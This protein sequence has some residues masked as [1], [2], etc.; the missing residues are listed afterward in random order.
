MNVSRNLKPHVALVSLLSA[1][2]TAASGCS[3]VVPRDGVPEDELDRIAQNL[4]YTLVQLPDSNP[5]TTTVQLSEPVTPFGR[6]VVERVREAGYGIQSVPDDRGANYLRYRVETI[7]SELGTETRYAVSIGDVSVERAYESRDGRL[8]PVSPQRVAGSDPDAVELNDDLFGDEPDPAIAAIAFEDEIAPS[9]VD[10]TGGRTDALAVTDDR[11]PA[12]AT[13]PFGARVKRNLYDGLSSNYA[14]LFAAYGDVS[15]DTIVF[16]NDSMRLGEA[17]KR[18]IE[19]YAERL[20]PDTDLL[21]VIGCSHGNTAIPAGNAL[22]A[23]GRANRVKEALIF[24]GVPAA[25]VLDEGCWASQAH[26]T[27]PGR[28]VV[29]TLKRRLG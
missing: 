4:V 16:P 17:Q 10:A 18:L 14:E 23:T 25:A 15:S 20:D 29:I 26:E 27:F 11:S 6:E 12:P 7:A 9:L 3:T 28:G 24:A 19:G 1:V 13:T 5:L 8:V 22:L 2:L 21:S